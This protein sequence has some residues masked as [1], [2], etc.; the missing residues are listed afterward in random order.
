MTKSNKIIV[1]NG[2]V[3]GSMVVFL[4]E[5]SFKFIREEVKIESTRLISKKEELKI[6]LVQTKLSSTIFR[7]LR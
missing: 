4:A 2:H 5:Q 1:I 3:G 7:R 6:G